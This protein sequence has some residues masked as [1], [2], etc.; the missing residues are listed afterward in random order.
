MSFPDKHTLLS[1]VSDPFKHSESLDEQLGFR[2]SEIEGKLLDEARSLRPSGN[3][4]TWGEG[5]HQ[6]SQSWIGLDH[7]TLQTPYSELARICELLGPRPSDH[8]VDLGAGYGRLG[9][10]LNVLCPGTRFTGY[11][12]VK[13]RVEEGD[14]V[15]AALGCEHARL[16]Q[17]DLTAPGFELPMAEFYFLYDYGKVEHIRR[18]LRQLEKIAD[19]KNFK[20]VAR[21]KGSRSL[22]EHEHPWLADVYPV[23]REANFSIYSMSLPDSPASGAPGDP[24]SF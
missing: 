11:E 6:G 18:T 14:R 8:L 20:L 2:V 5:L 23:H 13:E 10:V 24:G 3:V 17:Q 7:Q 16:Y 22:I 19:V 1:P 4:K 12:L 21:G 9:V 15:L